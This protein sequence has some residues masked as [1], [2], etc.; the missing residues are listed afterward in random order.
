MLIISI[1]TILFV[2]ITLFIVIWNIAKRHR[3]E[4]EENEKLYLSLLGQLDKYRSQL[5]R[6][7]FFSVVRGF[8]NVKEV[9]LQERIYEELKSDAARKLKR[10][11]EIVLASTFG[12]PMNANTE[13]LPN[14]NLSKSAKDNASHDSKKDS[15]EFPTKPSQIKDTRSFEEKAGAAL[16]LKKIVDEFEKRS[17]RLL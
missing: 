12:Q 16:K 6:E 15:F 7:D 1:F 8:L 13:R 2:F 11:L 14:E 4:K 5:N 10:N 3:K 17:K 9:E